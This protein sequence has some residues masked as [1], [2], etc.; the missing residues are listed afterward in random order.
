MLSRR[1]L[2]AETLDELEEVLIKADLGVAMATRIRDALGATRQ[3]RGLSAQGLREV[4]A[5]EIAK[6]LAPVAEPLTL[7]RV[8]A[9]T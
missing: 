5:A 3:D 6:V 4:L 7:R 1:K 8:P 9:P 2:D